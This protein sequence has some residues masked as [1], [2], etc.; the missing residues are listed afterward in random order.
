MQDYL[1][2]LLVL[3]GFASLKFEK[4]TTALRLGKRIPLG[5]LLDFDPNFLGDLP[6]GIFNPPFREVVSS[7]NDDDRQ[8]PRQSRTTAEEW[9]QKLA[10]DASVIQMPWDRTCLDQGS[11]TRVPAIMSCKACFF[12]VKPAMIKPM[13][14]VSAERILAK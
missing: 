11:R 7:G 3:D 10:S 5:A 4:S 12:S 9:I 14:R 8:G 6:Q 1:T 2:A 13:Q